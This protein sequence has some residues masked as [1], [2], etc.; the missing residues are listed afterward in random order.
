[1][2]KLTIAQLREIA[3]SKNIILKSNMRKSKIIEIINL[4]IHPRFQTPILK[5]K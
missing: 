4:N 2:D 3:K 5:I 1:M